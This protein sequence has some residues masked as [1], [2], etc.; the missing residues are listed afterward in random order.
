MVE[1]GMVYFLDDDNIVHPDFWSLEFYSSFFY[2]FDQLR[3]RKNPKN[4]LWGNK[5]EI[6][7]I[8][9]AMFIVPKSMC[10]DWDK[11]AYDAD[12]KF[13]VNIKKENPE[14]HIYIPK[15]AAYYNYLS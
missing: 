12:G 1:S 4:I 3:D 5:V 11:T 13:I 6:G 8:D 7:K 9:T 10:I 15:I 14:N 2:T